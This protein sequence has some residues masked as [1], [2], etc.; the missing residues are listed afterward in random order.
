MGVPELVEQI[1]DGTGDPVA[2]AGRLLTELHRGTPV[3]ELRPL[4][5]SADDTAV[6][7]GTWVASELAAGAVPVRDDALPLLRHPEREVRFYAIDVVA[8]TASG[9]YAHRVT[10]ILPL[11]ADPEPAVR[12]KA[13]GFLAR[14]TD[15]Q[16]RAAVADLRE[17]SPDSE[18]IERLD[19]LRSADPAGI[20]AAVQ[21]VDAGTRRYGVAAAARIA[22]RDRGPLE[23]AAHAEDPD[24]RRFAADML[25][26]TR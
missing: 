20:T 19:W 10:A 26:L 11:L 23:A 9:S 18:H 2:L 6:A 3:E 8:S 24:V 1:L 7:I 4:L 21:N 5:W 15:E 13:L 22:G 16:L 14:A 17:T 12:W 25:T